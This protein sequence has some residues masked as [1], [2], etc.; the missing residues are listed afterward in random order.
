MDVNIRRS[1][2]DDDE[3]ALKNVRNLYGERKYYSGMKVF[4]MGKIAS[5]CGILL[6]FFYIYIS[7]LVWIGLFSRM[8]VMVL[9][10]DLQYFFLL[11]KCSKNE[12]S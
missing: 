9:N 6:V 4:S 1:T 2:F 7:L 3:N 5:V 8:R 11:I 12:L 10:K